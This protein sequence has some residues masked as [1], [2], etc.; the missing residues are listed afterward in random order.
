MSVA[1]THDGTDWTVTAPVGIP[2]SALIRDAVA[3][4]WGY[5]AVGMPKADRIGTIWTSE[6]GATWTE[7]ETWNRADFSVA[8]LATSGD[9]VVAVGM[10]GSELFAWAS[11]DGTEWTRNRVD[12]PFRL[13]DPGIAWADGQFA[14]VGLASGRDRFFDGPVV[15]ASA[16]GFQWQYLDLDLR[17]EPA[18]VP[19]L[20]SGPQ[21]ATVGEKLRPERHPNFCVLFG[22]GDP[23]MRAYTF[24]EGRWWERQLPPMESNRWVARATQV[25][26]KLIVLNESESGLQAWIEGPMVQITAV[27]EPDIPEIP[28]EWVERDSDP[29]LEMGVKYA[30]YVGTHCGIDHLAK[31]HGVNWRVADGWVYPQGIDPYNDTFWGT[32]ELVAEDRIVF[33]VLGE[34]YAEYSPSDR[35][36]ICA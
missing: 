17:P 10:R 24:D 3:T 34:V 1:T 33:R 27:G 8:K 15:M 13:H 30:M 5:V 25:D 2:R 9:T 36:F 6:D 14:I 4:N 28:F 16:D 35:D 31:W 22:C 19:W 23:E 26:G 29:D 12:P 7:A 11:P 20:S 18:I 21:L 32:V